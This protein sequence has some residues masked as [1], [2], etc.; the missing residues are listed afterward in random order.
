MAMAAVAAMAML[1]IAGATGCGPVSSPPA[2][3]RVP[4]GFA[5]DSVTFAS[6][7]EA[8]V[9]GTAP[10]ATAPCT[11]ILRTL[12]RGATWASLSAPAVPIGR[13][14][15]GPS[16]QVWG[17]QF[18]TPEHGFVFGKGLWET[19]DGGQH[20][21]PVG[22]PGTWVVSLATID[23]QLLAVTKPQVVS[24]HAVIGDALVRRPLGGGAWQ[25]VALVPGNLGMDAISTQAGVATIA[26]NNGFPATSNGSILVT[27]N[28]GIT[29]STRTA[30]CSRKGFI[31]EVV[32]ATPT[33]RG[34]A[35]LCAGES[36][37]DPEHV[38]VTEYA[39]LYTS[40][41]LGAHWSTA[42]TPPN[43]PNYGFAAMA[44]SASGTLVIGMSG[45]PV[46]WLVRSVNGAA[47]WATV[48]SRASVAGPSWVDLGFTTQADGAVIYGPVDLIANPK[49][50]GQLFLTDDGGAT[51]HQARF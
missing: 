47:T 45:G 1:V 43:G 9:L 5:A 51:W 49:G 6:S 11:L 36:G 44:A 14:G 17:I 7:Q 41:D 37:Q 4:A 40:A 33:P 42:G 10:C 26:Y 19:T 21:A 22:I 16:P 30:P 28:G 46:S 12:D 29:I 38:S 8:F 35:V 50:P 2:G 32:G 15:T 23:G 13:F 25:Q 39:A 3:G 48:A 18:A 34:L 27:S 20:W 31:S 24:G